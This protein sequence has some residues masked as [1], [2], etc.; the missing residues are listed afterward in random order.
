MY[1]FVEPVEVDG[2]SFLGSFLRT[3]IVPLPCKNKIPFSLH[4]AE[5]NKFSSFT[6]KFASS[7]LFLATSRP[8]LGSLSFI[9]TTVS[10][11]GCNP[12]CSSAILTTSLSGSH[13]VF[14]K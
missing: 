10:V 14:P 12:N 6:G 9:S 3:P 2:A 11:V 8:L 4:A 1:S 7:N 13:G 5:I